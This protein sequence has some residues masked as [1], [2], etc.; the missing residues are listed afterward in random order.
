MQVGHVFLDVI[1]R[2]RWIIDT[3]VVPCDNHQS[4]SQETTET[5]NEQSPNSSDQ[6]IRLHVKKK[7]ILS[8]LSRFNPRDHHHHHQ[9]YL[10]KHQQMNVVKEFQRVIQQQHENNNNHAIKSERSDKNL[11]VTR[12]HPLSSLV[13]TVLMISNSFTSVFS[14]R[15]RLSDIHIFT[16]KLIQSFRT[17]SNNYNVF[18]NTLKI[19]N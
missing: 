8:D 4:M 5:I 19:I 2:S 6:P 17:E 15:I 12:E 14:I 1:T 7:F 16:R 3:D 18:N 13:M 9:D 11:P 10:F